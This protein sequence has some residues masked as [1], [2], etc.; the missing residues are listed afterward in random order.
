MWDPFGDAWRLQF[1][2]LKAYKQENGH[3]NV[4]RGKGKL[5]EWKLG[6]WVQ[7]Q[8]SLYN[9][10]HGSL[11]NA[12]KLNKPRKLSKERIDALNEIGFVWN[13]R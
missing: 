3:C 11:Y 5:G 10:T 2:E 12:G 8:R 6:R 7:I 13:L 1:E 4:P 9:G